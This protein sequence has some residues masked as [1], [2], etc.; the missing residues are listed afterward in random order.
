MMIMDFE[1]I[2]DRFFG[3]LMAGSIGAILAFFVRQSILAVG[4][5]VLI[6]VVVSIVGVTLFLV[7]FG[8]LLV[9]V[10]GPVVLFV[11]KRGKQW[12]KHYEGES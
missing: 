9:E 12:I 10:G 4:I 7:G 8:F 1:S 2:I 3:Y 6:E 5:Q 11:W